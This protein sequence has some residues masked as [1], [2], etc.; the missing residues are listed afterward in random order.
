MIIV[1]GLA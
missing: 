1:I